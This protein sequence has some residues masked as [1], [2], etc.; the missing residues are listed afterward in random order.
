MAALVTIGF[1]SESA[2][3]Q[4][5]SRPAPRMQFLIAALALPVGF[6]GDKCSPV[7]LVLG[8]AILCAFQLLLVLR[9]NLQS[10]KLQPSSEALDFG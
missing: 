9:Q 8:L 1:T 4:S 5:G 10:M 6:I 7:F 2:Q 3:R